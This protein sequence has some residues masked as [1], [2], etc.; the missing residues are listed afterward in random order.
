[1]CDNTGIMRIGIFGGTFNPVHA[2]HVETAKRALKEL[3]LDKLFIMPTFSSPHK[4]LMAA[5]AEDRINMLK[6]AFAGVPE[7]E[8]S[9]YET[10]KKGKSYTYLTV[11]EFK[12]RYPHDELFL[13]IGGDMLN[14]FRT[15]KNPEIIVGACTLCVF[16]REDYFTDYRKEEEYFKARFGKTFKRLSYVGK[17]CSSTKIRLYAA[18]SLGLDGICI[19]AVAEYIKDNNV[20]PA[21]KYVAFVTA[22]MPLKRRIHTASVAVTALK[23]AK[24][25]C[26]DQNKVMCAAVLHDCA[27]YLSPDD[28]KDFVLPKDVPAPV[29]HQYLGAYVAEK[30]LGVTDEEVLDAIRYH[31][32][33][34]PDMTTLGKLIFVA[35]MIEENRDYDGVENL[36]KLYEKDFEECF[37]ECLKEETL[38]LINKKEK[39]YGVT[40]SAYRYYIKDDKETG[41]DN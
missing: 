39:I 37:K 29:V 22:H 7:A 4:T 28:Y 14:D 25:L 13:I 9:T 24:E 35:D 5:S 38:H 3:N 1:M 12:N 23:K 11:T 34:K 32:S 33:G 27:K 18:F 21:D 16:G 15:W 30:V 26:L 10:D 8:I 2:E 41:A 36:R 20:Y 17:K 6:I 31:T 19:P 40:L